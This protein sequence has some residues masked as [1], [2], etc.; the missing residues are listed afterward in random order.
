[1]FF[2]GF[3]LRDPL[4]VLFFG[5]FDPRRLAFFRAFEAFFV[6]FVNAFASFVV[7]FADFFFFF[8][9][10]FFCFFELFFV[11]FFGFFHA[12]VFAFG[13]RRSLHADAG[14]HPA[15]EERREQRDGKL[16]PPIHT[17]LL[18]SLVSHTWKDE[19]ACAPATADAPGR[20][21]I[22]FSPQDWPARRHTVTACPS[23]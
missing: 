10:L 18:W 17:R 23:Q 1:M 14:D 6:L 4:G 13:R 9:A 16:P 5:L 2:L 19:S 8:F 12:G 22:R 20:E 11:D 15:G 3:S 21:R 7:F